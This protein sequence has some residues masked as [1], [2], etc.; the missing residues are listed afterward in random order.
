MGFGVKP[1]QS[2]PWCSL[3]MFNEAKRSSIVYR[4][5]RS[6][7]SPLEKKGEK[8]RKKAALQVKEPSCLEVNE[9]ACLSRRYDLLSRQLLPKYLR[10][11]QANFELRVSI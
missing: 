3:C 1:A 5:K 9:V 8:G 4:D 6:D 7:F 2:L 10:L 11:I